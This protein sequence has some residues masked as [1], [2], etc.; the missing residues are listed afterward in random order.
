ML[1]KILKIRINNIFASVIMTLIYSIN[2]KIS[3]LID[4][5]VF[6]GVIYMTYRFTYLGFAKPVITPIIYTFL[7]ITL[8]PNYI[9]EWFLIGLYLIIE[10]LNIMDDLYYF[11]YRNGYFDS[12]LFRIIYKKHDLGIELFKDDKEKEDE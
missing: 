8:F 5:I 3:N 9:I 11:A 1:E 10:N 7:L 4:L 6:F 2:I 12:E